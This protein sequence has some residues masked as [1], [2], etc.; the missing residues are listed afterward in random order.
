M[1]AVWAAAWCCY[2]VARGGGPG[3]PKTLALLEHLQ[4]FL[5]PFNLLVAISQASSWGEPLERVTK[6]SGEN[7]VGG[8]RKR[9]KG[10][11]YARCARR[12][13]IFLRSAGLGRFL[14]SSS[15][16]M[17]SAYEMVWFR[18]DRGAGGEAGS[19]VVEVGVAIVDD[20]ESR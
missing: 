5:E 10:V 2:L 19:E 15:G 4:L 18:P 14:Q 3:L 12:F 8:G 7:T 17:R 1:W 11:R 20:A 16:F 13:W 9:E 6:K